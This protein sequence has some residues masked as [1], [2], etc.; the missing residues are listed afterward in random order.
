MEDGFII[1]DALLFI[2]QGIIENFLNEEEESRTEFVGKYGS[3]NS[4]EAEIP[5]YSIFDSESGE[6]TEIICTT[7]LMKILG[8]YIAHHITFDAYFGAN[9]VFKVGH[10]SYLRRR[11]F[12]NGF[13]TCVLHKFK[14]VATAETETTKKAQ[15]IEKA[16]LRELAARGNF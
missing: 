1:E 10:T 4:D 6:E 11:L 2:K 9:Q 14:F 7:L 15:H 12:D 5:V 13:Q 3:Q 16:I 8:F